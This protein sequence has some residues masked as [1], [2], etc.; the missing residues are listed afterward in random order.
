[1][2]VGG[3]FIWGTGMPPHSYR[4]YLYNAPDRILTV[5]SIINL[6]THYLVN[7]YLPRRL[8]PR[9]TAELRLT[10][11]IGVEVYEP[12][13]RHLAQICP[14]KPA[15]IIHT[16]TAVNGKESIFYISGL[17]IRL[18]DYSAQYFRYLEQL[19]ATQTIAPEMTHIGQ[20]IR[21]LK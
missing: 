13:R 16:C 10:A 19:S 12:L 6:G 3:R 4:M 7:E 9:R 17:P 2:N 5:T 20:L 11:S 18:R 15:C 21:D 14:C 8:A 1:M